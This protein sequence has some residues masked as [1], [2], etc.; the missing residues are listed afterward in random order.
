VQFLDTTRAN[1]PPLTPSRRQGSIDSSPHDVRPQFED[2][3]WPD[4]G[5]RRIDT[6]GDIYAHPSHTHAV[7][8]LPH[9][10]RRISSTVESSYSS[11]HSPA[12][13]SA[14]SQQHRPSYS[15]PPSHA[16]AP[17]GA[18]VRHHSSPAPP[19]EPVYRHS[20]AHPGLTAH[21]AYH[22]P[23][24]PSA[25][26]HS[27]RQSYYQDS[28]AAPQSYGYDAVQDA[29]YGRSSY[30]GQAHAGYENGYGEVR[31]QQ[32]VGI[33]PNAF[34]RKRRG[35][36]PKEA[37]NMLKMWFQSHRAQPYPTE[38][39]KIELCQMSG[40]SMNQVRLMF[41]SDWRLTAVLRLPVSACHR[42]SGTCYCRRQSEI[43]TNTATLIACNVLIVN[44][45]RTGSSMPGVGPHSRKRANA[46]P[47]VVNRSSSDRAT[48]LYQRPST[49]AYPMSAVWLFDDASLGKWLRFVMLHHI[50]T[51]SLVNTALWTLCGYCTPTTSF[52]QFHHWVDHYTLIPFIIFFT[53]YLLL[54]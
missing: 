40:L 29:Y 22:P 38:D 49:C 47:T 15:F 46:K 33:D 5:H 19:Q 45:F 10:Q 44:R 37:T 9:E 39:Q 2:V 31:F 4:K 43:C 50:S 12:Y 8:Q 7:K 51:V 25:P 28:H 41:F 42:C 32:H 11:R 1:T 3:A 16:P 23:S 30:P 27:H 20:P 36:L 14:P 35:N 53:S 17:Y 21:G 34:S 24:A 48:V 13:V 26:V 52:F 54:P 6:L 18:H